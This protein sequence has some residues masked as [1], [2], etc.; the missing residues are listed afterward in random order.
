MTSGTCLASFSIIEF[1][2][3]SRSPMQLHSHSPGEGVHFD[4]TANI[5]GHKEARPSIFFK[6]TLSL[7]WMK[8]V[9]HY[10][11]TLSVFFGFF[12]HAKATSPHIRR[13]WYYCP[14]KWVTDTVHSL[15]RLSWRTPLN[16]KWEV[17]DGI[18]RNDK[19][20]RT[21]TFLVAFLEDEP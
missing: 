21:S 11:D 12:V 8:C 14:F 9:A 15:L 7:F 1:I 6:F 19:E 10:Y 18:K 5:P 13:D 3:S 20:K 17:T 16:N 2:N 4:K